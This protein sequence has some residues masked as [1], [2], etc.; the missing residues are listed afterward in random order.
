MLHAT[1]LGPAAR[2]DTSFVAAKCMAGWV[3]IRIGGNEEN[4]NFDQEYEYEFSK[5]LWTMNG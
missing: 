2:R 4:E 5:P 3:A 1:R